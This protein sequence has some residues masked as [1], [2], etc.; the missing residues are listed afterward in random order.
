MSTCAYPGCESVIAI[1]GGV[2]SCPACR[3]VIQFCAGCGSANRALARYCRACGAGIQF[4]S[5]SAD[6]LIG[7]GRAFT[8]DPTRTVI[9]DLFWLAPVSHGGSLLCL[10][11]AG[12]VYRFSPNSRSAT[13]VVTLGSGFGKC[14]FIVRDIRSGGNWLEPWLI[15]ASNRELKGVSLLTGAVSHFAEA[16]EGEEFVA[17]TPELYSALEADAE[18][19]YVL[20]RKG[21]VL[22]LSVVSLKDR[23]VRDFPVPSHTAAGPLRC[24]D[25]VIC[26]SANEMFWFSGTGIRRQAFT[27]GFAAWT[28]PE[29][30]DFHVPTGRLPY[31]VCGRSVYIPGSMGSARVLLLQYSR[32]GM[33]ESSVIRVP[34]EC[35]YTQA[36]SGQPVLAL[37]GRIAGLA[38]AVQRDIRVDQQIIARRGAFSEGG[39]TVCFADTA[40]GERL[41]IFLKLPHPIDVPLGKVPGFSDCLDYSILG[42]CFVMSYLTD[43]ENMGFAVWKA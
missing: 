37:A 19:L 43:A 25:T 36:A 33:G 34:G 14:A 20:K 30:S 18:S 28:Q 9:D 6:R 15:A 39:L 31:M 21:Q 10:S 2:E 40:G 17:N 13:P 42:S 22:H 11:I 23:S 16:G 38:E 5:P 12:Q 24:G 7:D 27:G 35:T 3:Q 26:Y 8:K 1:V 4:P 32:G 41:R 29:A